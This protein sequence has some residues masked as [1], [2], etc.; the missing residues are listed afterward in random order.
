MTI[1]IEQRTVFTALNNYVQS[2]VAAALKRS[3]T[4]GPLELAKQKSATA[5]QAAEGVSVADIKALNELGAALPPEA[6]AVVECAQLLLQ[7]KVDDPLLF[8]QTF[9]LS[10]LASAAKAKVEP[11]AL[12]RVL[13]RLAKPG[14]DRHSVVRACAPV[15]GLYEWT[16][17]V[18]EAAETGS[19]A[20]T[21]KKSSSAAY[22]S[23]KKKEARVP[24]VLLGAP[25]SGKSASL[26][27]WFLKNR[28]PGFVLAHF[29][30]LGGDHIS[31]L[32]RILSELQRAFHLEG[33]VP[34]TPDGC[35]ELFPSWLE[36]AC[37]HGQSIVLLIDGLDQLKAR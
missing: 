12:R 36:R 32:R 3:A 17:A 27:N 19:A 18:A 25:G 22:G 37:A 4:E 14:F 5:S 20:A 7:G 10:R 31:I 30:Q 2:G 21:A 23:D 15:A 16:R 8:L 34:T 13:D 24:L 9:P 28:R 6:L 26:A 35:I 29:I 33:E 1:H 11:A